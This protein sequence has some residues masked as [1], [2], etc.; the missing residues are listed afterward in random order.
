MYDPNEDFCVEAP[1]TH[2]LIKQEE[3]NVNNRTLVDRAAIKWEKECSGFNGVRRTNRRR[4]TRSWRGELYRAGM[5][6]DVCTHQDALVV[7]KR[8]NLICKLAGC[9]LPNPKAGFPESEDEIKFTN[10]G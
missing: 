8:L 9:V 5:R 4:K 2:D 6:L 7:A 10:N 1:K 3:R